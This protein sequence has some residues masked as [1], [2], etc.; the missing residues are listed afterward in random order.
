MEKEEREKKEKVETLIKDK[1]GRHIHK[2]MKEVDKDKKKEEP[3]VPQFP[4]E[5]QQEY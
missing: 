4:N 2:T 3:V 1:M 5:T